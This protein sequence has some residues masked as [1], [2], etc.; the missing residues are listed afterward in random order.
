MKTTQLLVLLGLWFV[1]TFVLG[2]VEEDYGDLDNLE[3]DGNVHNKEINNDVEFDA[4]SRRRRGWFYRR[5]SRFAGGRI[6]VCKYKTRKRCNFCI[7]NKCFC[8]YYKVK[9][10]D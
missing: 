4:Q 10:C 5:R 8:F 3:V 2:E 1:I 9:I 6:S 7:W